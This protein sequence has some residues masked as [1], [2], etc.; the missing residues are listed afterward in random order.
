MWPLPTLRCPRSQGGVP[1]IICGR[2]VTALATRWGLGANL[3]RE[4]GDADVGVPPLVARNLDLVGQLTALG[5]QQ[6]AGDRFERPLSDIPVAVVGDRDPRNYRATIDVLIPAYT[7]RPRQN[8]KV[9]T[10]LVTTEVLG[11]AIALGRAPV[12]LELDLR[13][14][15]G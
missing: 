15:N 13:R 12:T 3:Y 2:M 7:N 4:T 11:L 1:R 14:L 5:Y 9:G 6:V 10:D 8:V